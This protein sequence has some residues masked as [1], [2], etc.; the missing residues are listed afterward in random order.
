VELDWT[1]GRGEETRLGVGEGGRDVE[2]YAEDCWMWLVL[3]SVCEEC[4]FG[5]ARLS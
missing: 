1:V 3:G 5:C 2:V 4:F